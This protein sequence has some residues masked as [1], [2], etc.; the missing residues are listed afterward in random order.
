MVSI[1]YESI[2][3]NKQFLLVESSLINFHLYFNLKDQYFERPFL[4]DFFSLK[5]SN[6]NGL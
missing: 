4:F 3:E 6:K 1:K 5:K 2:V